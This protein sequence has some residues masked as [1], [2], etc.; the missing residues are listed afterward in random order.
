MLLDLKMQV[1][2]KIKENGKQLLDLNMQFTC[3]KKRKWKT[4]GMHVL[5]TLASGGKG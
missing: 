5:F 2:C 1:T 3:K 4:I